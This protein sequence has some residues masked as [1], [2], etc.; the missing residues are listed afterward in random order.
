MVRAA[1][2]AVTQRFRSAPISNDIIHMTRDVIYD[3]KCCIIY[4]ANVIWQFPRSSSSYGDQSEAYDIPSILRGNR[5]CELNFPLRPA[6]F[7]HQSC[8]MC[9]TMICNR[10]VPRNVVSRPSFGSCRYCAVKPCCDFRIR[11]YSP[12]GYSVPCPDSTNISFL[13]IRPPDFSF[14]TDM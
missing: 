9:G 8:Q 14:D 2:G 6:P 12:A 11:R 4:P 10:R 5:W 7:R 1:T 13:C 3:C